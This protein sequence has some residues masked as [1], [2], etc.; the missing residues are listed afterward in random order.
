MAIER[1][2]LTTFILFERVCELRSITRAAERSNM[3]V[4]AA[5]RRISLL[6]HAAGAALLVRRPHGVEPTSA[7][8][9]VLRYSRD[10]L[11]LCDRL[12]T[13]LAEHRGGIS[14]Q[15]RVYSSSS[16]LVECLAVHLSQFGQD[17]PLIKLE[18]EERPSVDTLEAL[19]RRQA[20]IGF[21][22]AGEDL[23][24]VVTHPYASDQLV[25]AVPRT[26][27]LAERTAVRLDDLVE[28]DHVALERGTAV[29]RLV[30]EKARAAGRILR[31]RVQVRSFDVMC[32][33]VGRGLGIGIL[34]RG[35]I[36]SLADA[37]D[38]ALVDLAE[39]WTRRQFIICLPEDETPSP[40]TRRLVDY[41]LDR[42][43]A[44]GA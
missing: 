11:H 20:D 7:G 17:N 29:H 28:E 38:I 39:D 30:M 26:H 23:S 33:M 5:S 44:K 43:K 15:I 34:P 36:G 2:D 25:V 12:K 42:S 16:V 40:S 22:V 18:L 41:L 19:R 9:V 4:S 27:R 14:G 10:I 8:L 24:G 31:T 37:L 1:Q 6:E 21:I 35:A 13:S 32:Q 3:T